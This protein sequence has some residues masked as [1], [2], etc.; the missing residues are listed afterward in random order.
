ME[1]N[2]VAI[3]YAV[4]FGNLSQK[5]SYPSSIPSN[6][7]SFIIQA[8]S[9]WHPYTEGT[10]WQWVNPSSKACLETSQQVKGFNTLKLFNYVFSFSKRTKPKH[11]CCCFLMT[12]VVKT[13]RLGLRKSNQDVREYWSRET[14]SHLSQQKYVIPKK[15]ADLSSF[16]HPGRVPQFHLDTG[17]K[18][19][20]DP[21][22][23]SWGQTEHG[24]SNLPLSG[25]QKP[26]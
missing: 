16:L 8:G 9:N 21:Y 19:P 1:S 11:I 18:F 12:V 24:F 14:Q 7:I 6:D 26:E 4:W 25:K 10:L 17:T 2:S 22:G 15:G 5:I 13:N 23:S 3:S 20:A